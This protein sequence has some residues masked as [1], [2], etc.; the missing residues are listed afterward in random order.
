MFLLSGLISLITAMSKS[1]LS[2][3]FRNTALPILPNPLIPTTRFSMGRRN[4]RCFKRFTIA[5]L[6]LLFRHELQGVV[7]RVFGIHHLAA[8]IGPGGYL[9]GFAPHPDIMPPQPF[10]E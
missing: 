7:V 2:S 5:S 3:T 10:H 8:L 1:R 6:E 9:L 4:S